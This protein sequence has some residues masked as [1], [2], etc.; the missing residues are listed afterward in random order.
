MIATVLD[1]YPIP[2]CAGLLGLEI[3]AADPGRG[4]ARLSF[5]ATAQFRNASGG[6]QAAYC[7]PC[8]TTP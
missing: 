7:P 1:R 8:S 5:T 3:L 2:P 4:W 6:I